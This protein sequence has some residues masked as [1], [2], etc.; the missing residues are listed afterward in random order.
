MSW[1]AGAFCQYDKDVFFCVPVPRIGPLHNTG[2]L[3]AVNLLSNATSGR[4]R[5]PRT[6]GRFCSAFRFINL[7]RITNDIQ[8]VPTAYLRPSLHSGQSIWDR[9]QDPC[10]C[11]LRQGGEAG[12][13]TYALLPVAL[14]LAK[15]STM[16]WWTGCPALAHLLSQHCNSIGNTRQIS[17]RSAN[18]SGSVSTAS[19]RC[20]SQLTA[21]VPGKYRPKRLSPVHKLGSCSAH[22]HCKYVYTL[23][24]CQCWARPWSY[25]IAAPDPAK[26]ESRHGGFRVFQGFS[27]ISPPV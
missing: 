25:C 4:L 11:D 21:S 13:T 1:A 9:V 2:A 10:P 23:L 6:H 17:R 8:D 18:E 24:Q 27:Q 12:M 20:K 5:V 22:C 16:V 15:R 26:H 19:L 14:T 3:T 7:F